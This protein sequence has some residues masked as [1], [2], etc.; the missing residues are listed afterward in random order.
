MGRG[1]SKRVTQEQR[2][3]HLLQAAW[4]NEVPA[5]ALSRISLGYPG[6]IF[7]LRRKGYLIS[8]RVE[9]VDG[10]SKHGFYRLGPPPTPGRSQRVA[11][12]KK[13]AQ[14]GKEQCSQPRLF[15]VVGRHCDEG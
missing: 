10:L 3:L 1:P 6:R 5:I 14:R 15:D 11:A 2:V 12:S 13:V 7:S 4:P 8:N 9:F